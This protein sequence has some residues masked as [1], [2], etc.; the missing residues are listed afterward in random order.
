MMP[1]L[2]KAWACV[3]LG[4]LKEPGCYL[5]VPGSKEE[6]PDCP[7]GYLRTAADGLPAPY[8]IDGLMHPGILA[9]ERTAEL[10]AGAIRAEE[11]SPKVRELVHIHRRE[12]QSKWEHEQEERKRGA[13]H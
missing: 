9:S 10:E 8:L 11:L 3:D 12:K 5:A 7:A 13:R 4:V 2:R 1:Q 6:F